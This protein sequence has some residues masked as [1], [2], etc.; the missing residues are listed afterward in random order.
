MPLLLRAYELWEQLARDSGREVYRLTGGLFIG[1][2]DC[3]HRRRQPAGQRGSGTCRTR[4]STPPRSARRFPTFTP[5]AGDVALYEAKAGFVRPEMTVQ[6]HLDLAER[7]GAD[8]R[9]GEEVLEWGETAGGVPSRTARGTYTAGQLV[10]CPARGR[11]SCSPSSASRSRSSARCCTGST[12]SAGTA[13]FVDHPIFIDENADGVQIYGFPAIDGPRGGVKVAFFRK[14]VV[15]TPETID[16]TVHEHEIAEMRDRVSRT[17]AR[18]RRAVPALGDLHVH[19]HPRR[20][21]RHRPPPGQRECDRGVRIL[22]ARLQVRPGGRRDP[23][24]PRDRPASTAHPIALFD[25]TTVGDHMTAI[26]SGHCGDACCATLGGDY[27]T[28]AAIFAAEQEPASSRRCGSARCAAPT[29]PSPGAFQKVQVGRESVLVVRG[30]DGLLRAFL[31][32]CR[33]RGAAAVHRDPRARCDATSAVPVPRLDLRAGRQAGRRT[34][35]RRLT[36]ENGAA[37]TA[38]RYGLVPVALTRVARLRL[39]VPG[40]R[41]A[42]V[43]DDVIGE[44]TERLGDPTPSTATASS[45][46][47]VGHRIVYDVAANW[48]LIVENFMECYHCASIHPELVEVLPEFAEGLRRPVLRRARRR[49]RFGR[50]R[51]HRRRHRRASARC[52]VSPTSRTAATTRSRSSRRCSS[53]WCPT[54]SSSTGCSRWRPTAPSSSATGSTPPTWWR[55]G[56]DLSRSVELFHRVNQQDFDAC[57]RTQPAMSSRAYRNGGVLVP[58]EHHIAE[59][60]EWV[61]S[62]I[63]R[64]RVRGWTA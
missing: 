37:S 44:V 29:S 21:L 62:Q 58:A 18:A 60:H 4:C 54:T 64:E 25:P 8:L 39:G 56:R 30:R 36:D 1:P 24:R 47:E 55:P 20:A 23:R 40:R 17:A 38:Y 52:P 51:V 42:V 46:L 3:L 34:Q 5:R 28:S 7:A 31:N 15:C 11:R 59:F 61:V 12:R 26:D 27:Y 14:G 35:H 19:Q 48:K 2:P 57:E 45:G 33:H 10:I 32:V 22:R 13:P 53:T 41:A 43:R 6:A 50:R 49:V 16:R 9:F 63:D